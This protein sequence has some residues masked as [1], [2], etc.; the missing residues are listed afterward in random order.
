MKKLLLAGL[1]LAGCSSVSGNVV[2]DVVNPPNKD[3]LVAKAIIQG[4]QNATYNFDMAVQVGALPKSDPAAGCFH[5]LE[6]QLGIDPQNPPPAGSS[7]TPKVTDVI[8]LGSVLYIRAQ[9]LQSLQGG[10]IQVPSDCK[11]LI[12]TV[13]MDALRAGIKGL[14][15][16]GNA[17]LFK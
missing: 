14:P 16:G 8:S 17:I 6:T 1:M 11:A 4:I 3:D 13:T 9:Q 5:N 10:G 15:G 12:G 7:F 2:Q